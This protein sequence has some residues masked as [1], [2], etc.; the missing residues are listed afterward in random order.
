MLAAYVVEIYNSLNVILITEKTL[1]I[2]VEYYTK[3]TYTQVS[4][5]EVDFGGRLANHQGQHIFK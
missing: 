2:V 1:L 4:F 5:R 3:V